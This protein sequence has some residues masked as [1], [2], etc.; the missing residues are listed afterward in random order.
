MDYSADC[1]YRG[2]RNTAIT[3]VTDEA[4]EEP[5]VRGVLVG[6]DGL[7]R[8]T[9]IT[10]VVLPVLVYEMTRSPASV[11]TVGLME[12]VPYL[13]FGLLAGAVADRVNR[14]K[15]M[16]GCDA[17]AAL[18]LASVPATAAFHLLGIA[19]VLIVALGIATVYVWFDA[20]N[21]G[22]L[23]ALVDRAE[24]PVAASLLGSSGQVALLCAPTAGAALL[25]VMSPPSRSVSTRRPISSRPCCCCRSGGHSPGRGPSRTPGGS[26]RTSPRVCGSCGSSR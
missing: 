21:F 5:G 4:A 3:E 7:V 24:L 8:G 15:I 14:K 22:T 13:A 17:T 12:F 18:L 25:T 23:P 11:A 9:G 26:A 16:V 10:T 1:L 6:A 20:A 2:S 19:Q